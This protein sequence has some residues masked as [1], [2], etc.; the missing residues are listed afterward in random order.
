M[1]IIVSVD[2]LR[3][4]SVLSV[5]AAEKMNEANEVINS[6]VSEHDWKCPE[7]VAVDQTLENI[8]ENSVILN[9]AFMDFSKQIAV[10]ANDYTDFINSEGQ[11]EATYLDDV[12]AL[13]SLLSSKT[14]TS[15]IMSGNN[16]CTIVSDLASESLNTANIASLNGATRGISIV[17]FSLFT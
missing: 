7:R 3:T 10:I 17:D 14:N 13:L 6:V 12:G 16:T 4:I 1:R 8:K 5:N 9:N 15:D 2:D 11:F